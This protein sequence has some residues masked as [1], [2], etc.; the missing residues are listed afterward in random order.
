MLLESSSIDS[1]KNLKTKVG[2]GFAIDHLEHGSVKACM[3]ASMLTTFLH[4]PCTENCHRAL[5]RDARDFYMDLAWGTW[6]GVR[7]FYKSNSSTMTGPSTMVS[8]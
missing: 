7:D 4:G 8:K 3:H 5:I 6:H 1:V 2:G